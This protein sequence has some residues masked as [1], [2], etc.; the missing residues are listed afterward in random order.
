M[1]SNIKYTY[2]TM[3]KYLYLFLFILVIIGGIYL[4]ISSV[5]L[6]NDTRAKRSVTMGHKYAEKV[7]KEYTI[8]GEIC[9]GVDTD[10][11]GYV[12][13]TFRISK[14]GLEK[15]INLQ[16]PTF[17][18]SFLGNECKTTQMVLPQ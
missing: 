17:I 3:K 1:D 8:L 13:C 6:V 18:K 5:S 14:D 10:S 12:S 4:Y 15:E 16:C 9:Q 7:Y 2:I 11:D